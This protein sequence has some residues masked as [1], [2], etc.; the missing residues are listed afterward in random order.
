M[1]RLLKR[2][3]EPDK[4]LFFESPPFAR[5]GYQMTERIKITRKNELLKNKK[6]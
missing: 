6:R 5:P 4:D 2:Q 3:V 1:T